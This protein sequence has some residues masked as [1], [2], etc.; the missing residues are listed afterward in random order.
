MSLITYLIIILIYSIIGT[1]AVMGLTDNQFENM[2][3]IK[4][5]LLVLF[6]PVFLIVIIVAI[7]FKNLLEELD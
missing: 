6:W 4:I 7:T 3:A 5:L 1:G 2:N